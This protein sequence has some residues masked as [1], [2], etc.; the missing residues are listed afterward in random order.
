[1]PHEYDVPIRSDDHA[2]FCRREAERRYNGRLIRDDGDCL[3][4]DSDGVCHTDAVLRA[5]SNWV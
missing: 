4:E 2:E 5:L 3:V 1:M